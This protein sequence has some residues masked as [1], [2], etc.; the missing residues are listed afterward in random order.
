VATVLGEKSQTIVSLINNLNVVLQNLAEHSQ[1]IRTLLVSTDSASHE[2]ANL[3]SRNRPALDTTL[4]FLHHDLD[5]LAKHQVDLAAGVSYL[6]QAVQGYSSVGYSNGV[7]NHWANIFVQSLGPLGVDAALGKC[8]AVDQFFDQ[9]FGTDC[10]KSD[11]FSEIKI[12]GAPQ[13]PQVGTA[14]SLGTGTLSGLNLNVP[15]PEL[16]NI[17]LPCSIDDLV[18]GVLA[19]QPQG[20][21]P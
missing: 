15:L 19:A 7:P 12:P 9:F 18:K 2:T 14:P 6:E 20:C 8:G 16:P 3:V 10:S 4:S 1:D 11:N 17:P 5:L 21:L 13:T